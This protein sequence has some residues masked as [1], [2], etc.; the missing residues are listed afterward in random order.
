M[1]IFRQFCDKKSIFNEEFFSLIYASTYS[2][3]LLDIRYLLVGL[4]DKFDFSRE[5]NVLVFGG[6]GLQI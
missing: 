2:T 1:Y 5:G 4:I 6:Q 3:S